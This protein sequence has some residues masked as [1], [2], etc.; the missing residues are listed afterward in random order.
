MGLLV[1][2]YLD[3]LHC[4]NPWI[5]LPATAQHLLRTDPAEDTEGFFIAL[6]VKKHDA[7]K[8]NKATEQPQRLQRKKALW[9][10]GSVVLPFK[11]MMLYNAMM[12]SNK[13]KNRA[14]N[15]L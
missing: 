2:K 15:R 12:R 7:N 10:Q 5:L 3:N 6:F 11:K 8:P 13:N 14:C 9:K 4:F 1:I